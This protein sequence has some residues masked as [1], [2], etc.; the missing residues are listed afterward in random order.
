MVR[1]FDKS[2]YDQFSSRIERN[3]FLRGLCKELF[4]TNDSFVYGKHKNIPFNYFTLIISS[5]YIVKLT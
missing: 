4:S 1:Y 3:V 2:K 5:R